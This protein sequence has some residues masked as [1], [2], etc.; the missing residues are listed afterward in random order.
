MGNENSMG[1]Q[2][3]RD[4]ASSAAHYFIRPYGIYHK[5]NVYWD[6]KLPRKKG[7]IVR[8]FEDA[9]G[10]CLS[11][12]VLNIDGEFITNAWP[13]AWCEN[14]HPAQREF[15]QWWEGLS[16]AERDDILKDGQGEW[17]AGHFGKE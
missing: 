17:E 5:G 16:K 1:F 7:T 2:S 4:A 11:L 9:S 15:N 6:A 10:P 3:F 8:Y 14:D 13:V 12:V